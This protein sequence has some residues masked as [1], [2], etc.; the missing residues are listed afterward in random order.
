MDDRAVAFL[1]RLLDAPGPSGY[2][3]P[4]A[5]VWRDEA[6]GF[7]DEVTHDV[8]GSSFAR[9]KPK[10]DAPDAPKVLLAGHIDEI[11]F[12]ITHID[13]EGF[14]WFSPLGGWDDQVVVGQRLRIAGRDG[15]VIGVIGKK[16]S[17][18]L[19]E[20]DRRRPTRLDEMWID[21]GARDHD[22]ASRRVSVGDAAVIDS[23]FIELS[24]DIC[25]ARS[26]DNRV[27]AFVALEA[28]RLVA[29]ARGAADV[30]AVATAQEEITFGG[31]Y[32]ASF[33]V[34]PMVAIAIDVTHATDYPGADKK[35]NHE[36]KLGGGPVLGR[37]ATI[38]DGVFHGLREAARTLEIETAVQATGKST[39]TDADA[40]L[41]SGTGTATGVVSIPNR[42]MHS[43]NEL[44]SLSDLENAARVIAGFIQ[45]VTAEADFRPGS[46][47]APERA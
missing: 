24:G 8:V 14:L 4:P 41:R 42:Y 32:T 46:S 35:R 22:D 21:I 31:A 9:V 23:R 19:K 17:H 28:A 44:V 43:P 33:S 26:M 39:G 2:E 45:T 25:V 27:G 16:A 7:A 37:G 13:K 47:R 36:A 18:L 5:Q 15:D 20:E 30:Y 29:A 1:R 6:S 10:N 38:N 40:M 12:V 34:A 11:G 3:S